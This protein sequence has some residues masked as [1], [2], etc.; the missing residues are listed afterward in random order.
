MKPS[1]G[2]SVV[3]WGLLLFAVL[4]AGLFRTDLYRT[5]L[6]PESSAGSLEF[7]VEAER[8]RPMANS[9]QVLAVG[10]SRMA[11]RAWMANGLQSGIT[12]GNAGIAGATPRVWN[13]V[14][15]AVDPRRDRYEALLF[16]VDDYDD[17]DMAEDLRNRRYDAQSL[18]ARI[19]LSDVAGLVLSYESWP[20]RLE[21]LRNVLLKGF[22]YKRDVQDFLKNPRQRL[23]DIEFKKNQWD[24]V[25]RGYRGDDHTLEGLRIDWTTMTATYPDRLTERE[26][27]LIDD[28]LLRPAF[29]QTGRMGAYRREWWG[30]ILAR[31]RG[32][33]TRILF[34][35]VPRGPFARPDSLVTKQSSTIRDLA[36]R[37]G[38]TLLDE[39]LLDYLE[40]PEFFMD[41]LHLNAEGCRRLT[42]TLTRRVSEVLEPGSAL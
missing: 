33:R 18:A 36:S 39:H 31:Y 40:R 23:A 22:A 15:R 5:F 27:K 9:R 4:E 20:E 26:R 10:D 1:R 8:T 32:T 21:V 38:V 19:G 2:W 3:A 7:V 30:R 24:E 37:P 28:V 6:A 14:V 34:C 41:A 13:Y 16:L 12:F 11:L 25:L 29:K 17:E 35:R 42:E